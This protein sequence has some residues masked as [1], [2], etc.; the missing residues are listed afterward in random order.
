MYTEKGKKARRSS[1]PCPTH[2]YSQNFNTPADS[3]VKNKKYIILTNFQRPT[4]FVFF[5][6]FSPATRRTWRSRD[7]DDDDNNIIRRF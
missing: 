2:F 6:F 5:S 1:K 4:F 3:S 7:D